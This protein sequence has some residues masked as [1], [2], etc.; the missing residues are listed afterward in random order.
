MLVSE[1]I[2]VG[3][4]R[5]SVESLT[6]QDFAVSVTSHQASHQ[7]GSGLIEEMSCPLL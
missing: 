1:F 2:Y 5:E 3:P 6:L 4:F 7:S